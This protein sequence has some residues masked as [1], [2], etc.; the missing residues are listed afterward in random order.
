MIQDT[1]SDQKSDEA[2][3]FR[4]L[5]SAPGVAAVAEP[6]AWNDGIPTE[7]HR[8]CSSGSVGDAFDCAELKRQKQ[9]ENVP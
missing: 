2:E 5:V 1:E 6:F 9:G 3:T 4:A 7:S 8:S